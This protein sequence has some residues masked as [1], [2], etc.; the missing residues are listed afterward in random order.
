MRQIYISSCDPSG[1]IY[2]FALDGGKL[3]LLDKTPLD[4]PM[5]TVLSQKKLY[6]LLRQTDTGTNH[7]G[8][9]HLAVNADGSLGQP[10]P[11][12]SSAGVVPCH[13]SVFRGKVYLVNYL[14]GNVVCVGGP[15]RQH[16][17]SSVNTARQ[18]A[19]HT[20]FV[21]PSPDGKYLLCCDLGLDR[22]F[23]L[24]A[25]LNGVCSVQT[26][27]GD[28]PRHLAYS[29]DGQFV[30]CA[31]ELSSTVGVYA[32]A[33]GRLSLLRTVSCAEK[34]EGNA[35]AAIRWR[36]GLLWVSN[37]GEDT[38]SCFRTEADRLEPAGR[39]PVGGS[40]PRDFAFADG[41]LVCANEHSDSVTVF[42]VEGEKLLQTDTV[43]GIPSP[44]CVTVL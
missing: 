41:Y 43:S 28:G 30:Y 25:E 34:P 14:S 37:R 39:T 23:T 19:P 26:L 38:I 10:A 1:G 6:V 27:P 11:V 13:L 7:G 4:R 3:R 15:V 32:Y 44:L 18:E 2:R 33:D 22:I 17:G 5:Y 24:D 8:V 36:D 31:N 42:R 40:F 35:P 29:E 9:T 12:V 16:S 20:H 21:Q